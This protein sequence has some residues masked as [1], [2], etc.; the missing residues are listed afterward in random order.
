M[1]DLEDK[2]EV[3]DRRRNPA[4]R[5]NSRVL[6]AADG[7]DG[8]LRWIIPFAFPFVFFFVEDMVVS[9]KRVLALSRADEGI[10]YNPC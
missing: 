6:T 10:I 8:T 2:N 9:G 3:V 7:S 4:D 1:E 5:L